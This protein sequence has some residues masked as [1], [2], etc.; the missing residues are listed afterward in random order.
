AQ[1]GSTYTETRMFKRQFVKQLEAVCGAYKQANVEPTKA[2][3]VLRP[4]PT[5][6][7]RRRRSIGTPER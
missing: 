4:S 2:G 7:P 3:L 6:V 1:F 5:H